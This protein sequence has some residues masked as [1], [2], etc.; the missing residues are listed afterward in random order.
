[1]LKHYTFTKYSAI[2]TDTYYFIR[3]KTIYISSLQKGLVFENEAF[4]VISV[5]KVQDKTGKDYYKVVLGDKTGKIDGKIWN[6]KISGINTSILKSGKVLGV[7]GK[8]DDFKG[9]PQ[10]NIFLVSEVDET[11]L[12]D[13]L[14]S[15][16]FPVEEMEKELQS[17]IEEI[18][19]ENIKKVILNI[20]NHDPI[21]SKFKFWPAGNSVHHNFRSGMLQH[22]LEMFD[23]L[24]SLKRFY[25]DA[26]YDILSA[27]IILHDI[28]KVEELMGGIN[29][30]SGY[31]LRGSLI[32]H[33]TLGSLIFH[34]FA[35]DVL[36][37]EDYIHILHL[38]LSHHGALEFGSPVFPATLEA[39]I[40]THIDNLSSKTRTAE[41]F[42]RRVPE[43]EN[44]T[45]Y[46][47]WLNNVRLW[48][49]KLKVLNDQLEVVN[50][51][52][53]SSDLTL[54]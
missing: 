49:G 42:L 5:E 18:K 27:G 19:D 11:V 33:I 53:S 44:L 26:N 47:R 46:C 36:P 9:I 7:S 51:E 13:F 21:K 28:G 1:M 23:I 20:L 41:N 15:S 48:N 50:K 40:L 6:D 24:E 12:E 43:N 25:P 52:N 38:I 29:T 30:G 39:T 4:L 34:D 10:L 45:D 8:V 2:I 54:F 22:I 35:K 37:E 17:K 31:T 3:M 14:E 32:G 16:M